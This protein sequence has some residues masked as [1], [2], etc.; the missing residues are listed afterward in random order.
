MKNRTG[1][2]RSLLA[3]Q[4]SLWGPYQLCYLSWKPLLLPLLL[5]LH[6]YYNYYNHNW[7]C[8]DDEDGDDD[9]ALVLMMMMMMMMMWLM[10]IIFFLVMIMMMM[11]MMMKIRWRTRTRRDRREGEGPLRGEAVCTLSMRL[12]GA[13]ITQQWSKDIKA[14]SSDRLET[15]PL[16]PF[17]LIIEPPAVRQIRHNNP[18][19]NL[20]VSD[21]T[22]ECPVRWMGFHMSNTTFTLIWYTNDSFFTCNSMHTFYEFH[23]SRVLFL[24]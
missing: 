7:W 1:H 18:F 3:E 22:P 23:F 24:N 9:Y 4:L 5:L 17:Y 11:M 19:Q 15:S 12:W 13:D 16:I 8:R 6:N 10:M 21:I 2:W 14:W 20:P